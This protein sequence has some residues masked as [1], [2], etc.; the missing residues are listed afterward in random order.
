[1]LWENTFTPSSV[2]DFC[3]HSMSRESRRVLTRT[4]TP[5][6]SGTNNK[7]IQKHSTKQTG[8]DLY[9][10]KWKNSH[11]YRLFKP[12][13]CQCWKKAQRES[14]Q[15]PLPSKRNKKL[16]KLGKISIQPI[17]VGCLGTC[18]KQMANEIKTLKKQLK[19]NIHLCTLQK[20]VVEESV[21]MINSL[22]HLEQ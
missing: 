21:K 3:C 7:N 10:Q 19:L 18:S 17:V 14:V 4:K 12:M 15:V 22:P 5:K 6:Y 1:M 8:H 20:I 16:W 2:K 13:G 11:R 9:Q